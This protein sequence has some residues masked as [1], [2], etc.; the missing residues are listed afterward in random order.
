MIAY[1]MKDI[2]ITST[3]YTFHTRN[4]FQ[5]WKWPTSMI[6][7]DIWLKIWGIRFLYNFMDELIF[8]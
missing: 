2:I 8:A 1:V 3:F 6:M 4:D 7:R 5:E